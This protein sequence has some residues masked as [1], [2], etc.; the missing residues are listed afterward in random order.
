MGQFRHHPQTLT[1]EVG[2][3]IYQRN[4]DISERESE[5]NSLL[6]QENSC[7]LAP[8]LQRR[9]RTWHPPHPCLLA[10]T[11]SPPPA[12]LCGEA[13]SLERNPFHRKALNCEVICGFEDAFK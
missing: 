3:R 1:R 13:P 12:F 11:C 5:H 4:R 10:E 6:L 7:K 2:H 9:A 8:T